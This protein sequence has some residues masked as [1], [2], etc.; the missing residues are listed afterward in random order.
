[1]ETD[2]PAWYRGVPTV[3]KWWLTGAFVLTLAANFNLISAYYLILDWENFAHK[4]QFW[5]II[6]AFLFMGKLGFP[7]L[8]N[9]I[10]LY[11]YSRQ[12]EDGLYGGRRADYVFQLSFMVIVLLIVGFL[13]PLRIL[14]L[15]LILA[16]LYVWC[17]VNADVVVSFYFGLKFKATYFPWVL[18][19]FNVLLG[20]DAFNELLGIAVGHLYYVLEYKFPETGGR[21]ILH[22]PQFLYSLFPNTRASG[23]HGFAA[24]PPRQAAQPQAEGRRDWGR[25]NV[26][27]ET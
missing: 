18:A 13:W 22:T 17:Q 20:G 26:L 27:G 14:G 24:P 21:R 7:F 5:R 15:A 9:L 8:I 12:N 11:Q 10:F 25:G 3:T 19:A 16:N 23:V 1:M 2:I 4:F 6:T